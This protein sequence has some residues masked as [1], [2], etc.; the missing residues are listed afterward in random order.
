MAAELET[1]MY[2]GEVPWHTEGRY[3][4]DEPVTSKEAI[5]AAELDW[6]VATQPLFTTV[7]DLSVPVKTHKA[8]VRDID[9]SVLGIVG[10][11]YTP[12]QN[13]EAFTFMDSLV[14]DGSMRYHTAGSLRGGQRIWLLGQIGSVDI[15]PSDR[16][17]QF[18]FL[19]NS[20]DGS[21]SLR[22]LFTNVRVVCANTAR[23]AL[24]I[25]KGEGIS[26]R[27]TANIQSR[28]E[29]T[30]DVLGLS[31]SCFQESTV[32][33]KELTQLKM[34]V[35]RWTEFSEALIPDNP[36]LDSNSRAEN[37]RFKLTQLFEDGVGS[38]IKG[39]RGT[40]W[41]AQCAVIEFANYHRTSRG[42]DKAQA[43]R[44]ES[45]LFDSGAKL[46]HKG[47]HLLDDYLRMAA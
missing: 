30:R 46:I 5:I 7:G 22:C 39:V 24:D 13:A 41:G 9:N 42:G 6:R 21:G 8:I 34:P 27:H 40:G 10:N 23:A 18:L 36:E 15:L 19:W 29:K 4:G 2:T 32:F 33:A 12:V 25:G 37:A 44:F 45:S 43:R 35:K 28:V 16:V 1:M 38:D 11:R 20:H 14:D 26:L 17:D 47:N 3:I 31:V